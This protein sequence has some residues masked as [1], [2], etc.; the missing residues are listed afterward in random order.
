M[1]WNG[2]WRLP[3]T[4]DGIWDPGTDGTTTA[5]YNI[6][7]SELG[8]LYYTELGNNAL[9]DTGGVVNPIHGLINKGD[10]DWLNILKYWSDTDNEMN[11]TVA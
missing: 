5:G 6:T 2:N 8:H 10:F 4:L 7:S 3:A 9:Y 1:I 11:E